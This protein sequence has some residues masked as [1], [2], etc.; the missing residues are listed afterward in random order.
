M[1]VYNLHVFPDA[2]QNARKS[3]I[4]FDYIVTV[5]GGDDDDGMMCKR[6]LHYYDNIPQST[7]DVTMQPGD[8]LYIPAFWFHH[9]ENGYSRHDKNA[10]RELDDAPSISLNSFGVFLGSLE[11]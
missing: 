11:T 2:H 5:G 10:N 1:G 3:Q 4:D 9:V 7:L 6:F 8:A